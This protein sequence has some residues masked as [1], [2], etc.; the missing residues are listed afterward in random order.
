MCS[1]ADLCLT[2]LAIIFPPI[3]VWIKRGLCS[4]DSL[5]NFALCL[6][7]FVPGLLHAWYIIFTTPPDYESLAATDLERGQAG[8]GVHVHHHHH[9]NNNN[10]V[11]QQPQRRLEGTQAKLGAGKKKG[12]GAIAAPQQQVGGNASSSAAAAGH[13]HGNVETPPSYAEALSGDHK[14]QSS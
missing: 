10:T 12:Y 5:I 13:G 14:V 11:G 2:I 1:P 4:A 7:G 3:P 8:R 9:N 6:L